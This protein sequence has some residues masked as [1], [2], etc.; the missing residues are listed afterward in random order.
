MFPTNRPVKMEGVSFKVVLVLTLVWSGVKAESCDDMGRK[1]MQEEFNTCVN[2]FMQKHHE[3]VAKSNTKSEIQSVTCQM[4]K[5]TVEC[6]NLWSRCHNSQ[7]IRSQKDMHIAARIQQYQDRPYDVDVNQ[8]PVIQEYLRSGRANQKR[9][10]EERCT[11]E[12]VF[13]VQGQFQSCSHNVSGDVWNQIKDKEDAKRM[14]MRKDNPDIDY[15]E[16]ILNT[17]TDIQP[18]ICLA[19]HEIKEECILP[20]SGSQTLV[21]KYI[22]HHIHIVDFL[23][24][25]LLLLLVVLFFFNHLPVIISY[26]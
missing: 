25:L 14:A 16:N 6:G 18:L 12:Q 26:P 3:A 22:I 21:F 20:K 1:Q 23:F 5:D 17:E 10:E 7:E 19:L 4:L 24:F 11:S 2:K 9:S 15:E 13:T 8:C